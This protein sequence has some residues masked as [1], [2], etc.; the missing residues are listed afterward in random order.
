MYFVEIVR[1]IVED[2]ENAEGINF[3]KLTQYDIDVGVIAVVSID[4]RISNRKLRDRPEML[5]DVIKSGF[6]GDGCESR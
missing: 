1:T 5:R 4:R 6:L 2:I 3:K